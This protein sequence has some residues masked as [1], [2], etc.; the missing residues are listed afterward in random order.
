MYFILIYQVL[1]M[2]KKRILSGIQPSGI[3]HLGNYFGAIAQYLE[4]QDENESFI[5]IANYHAMTSIKNK[6]ELKKNTLEV[7]IDYLAIGL[8]PAKVNLF[9]QSDIP[10]VCELSWILSTITPMGLLERCHSYKDKIE[11]GILPDHGLFAYPVLMAA[12]ILIYKSDIVPVGKDQKQHVEVARDIAIK[13]NNQYGN[14]LKIPDIKIQQN[15]AVVPGIDGQKMSKSYNNIIPIF[16]DEKRIKKQVMNIVTDSTPLEAPKDPENCN[17]FAI[18]KLLASSEEI[19]IMRN[20]YHKGGY[21]YGDAKKE[22][23]SKILEYFKQA[24][25]KYQDLQ[26]NLDYVESVLKN[27]AEKARAAAI[28]TMEQVRNAVGV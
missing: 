15:S 26:N 28:K 13:F 2:N 5:F 4:L 27:G 7:A 25:N 21:G 19:E 24:R 8:D 1:L 23:L 12:D 17:I 11:K 22:L 16:E 9:K 3:I 10:E 6:D 14:V 20:K 18:Y